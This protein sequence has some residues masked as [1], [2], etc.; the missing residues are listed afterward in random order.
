[1]AEHRDDMM[2][3]LEVQRMV[4]KRK[5]KEF[6]KDNPARVRQL[7]MAYNEEDAIFLLGELR[8]LFYGKLD[9]M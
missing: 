8:E 6:I 5:A 2:C 9:R 4:T 3:R 7:L 1:M